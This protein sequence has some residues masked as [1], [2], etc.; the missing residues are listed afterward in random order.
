MR[1]TK[2][3]FCVLLFLSAFSLL[4]K[5]ELISSTNFEN[6]KPGIS[7]SRL[8]FNQE[9]FETASWDNA[10]E[11]RT[12]VDFPESHSGTQ[13][14]RITYP[15]DSYGPEGTGC[16]VRL[17][18]D[19]RE[20]VYASYCLRFSENFSWG[21]TSYGGKL[22]G[23]A[24]GDCCSGGAEC[25][26]TN[27][28][29]AR[30][31]WRADGKAILYLYHMDKPSQ[32]GEDVDL[33][34]PDGTPVRFEKG[35]W[36]HIA[37][38]VR[39]NSD[40]ETFDGE[41]EIWVNGEPVLLMKGL[42]FTS[43]EDKVDC[44]YISTFH[45]GDDET[46]CPTDTCYTWLDDIRIGTAYED[47][48]YQK[49]SK[50]EL[51]Y[52]RSLCSGAI[53]YTLSASTDTSLVYSWLAN[54]SVISHEPEINVW[55]PGIYV[56]V[57][58]SAWCGARD[59]V[60]LL[61]V[62][63]PNL[64]DDISLCTQTEALLSPR[65]KDDLDYRYEWFKD[66]VL[67]PNSSHDLR[68]TAPGTYVVK[69]YSSQCEPVSDTIVV[70]SRLLPVEISPEEDSSLRL[71]VKGEGDFVWYADSSLGKIVGTGDVFSVVA[72]DS[73]QTFYVKDDNGFDGLIGKPYLSRNAWTR[74]NFDTEWMNFTVERP[75]T[76]DSISIYP[77]STLDA[78]V[79]VLNDKTE[80][81]LFCDT[82][83]SLEVGERRLPLHLSLP[84]GKYRMDALGTTGSL[85]H[86]HSDEDISFPYKVEGLLS[87]DGC[88]L[89][90]INDKKWYMFFY[91]WR[92]SSGNS[93]A[94]TP[95][96]VPSLGEFVAISQETSNQ[97]FYYI[98]NGILFIRNLPENSHV[99]LYD[100]NGALIGQSYNKSGGEIEVRLDGVE[101]PFLL[102]IR[103]G[104]I[105]TIYKMIKN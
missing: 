74:K 51:G 101:T 58:D 96:S 36:Y 82:F 32:Y 59:T 14:M 31:M 49:C 21:T 65:V 73:V 97:L 62:L 24:G 60:S 61:R 64:G 94:A 7:M 53:S 72:D 12:L 75:L 39:N 102:S 100:V 95:V 90:W 55:T 57:V 80:E 67:L 1:V 92:V 98:S 46:W 43:N 18:F 20:E 26:G 68:V 71:E 104:L 17:M 56:L 37:E 33:F 25:D 13:S 105:Q 47:V 86:S 99:A 34:Y 5:A 38:R 4:C 3:R 10:L 30:L 23:L 81:I 15:K 28:F 69:L 83:T 6:L 76:I 66:D 41:V 91:K 27:G 40:G 45:G 42:R 63:N 48:S 79:R 2:Q 22:P 103:K 19:P 87:I 70:S 78:V 54:D 11:T 50:P 44:L 8:L 89:Q 35:R 84:K 52:D 85:Y 93:C 77:V 29:S 16:Q 88:N 9:G